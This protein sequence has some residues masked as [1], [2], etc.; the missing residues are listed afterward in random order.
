[1]ILV[2]VYVVYRTKI[3]DQ[4]ISKVLETVPQDGR[5]VRT[6]D[7]N[8]RNKICVSTF[9]ECHDRG[10]PSISSVLPNR[11]PHLYERINKVNGIRSKSRESV[12]DGR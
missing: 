6:N 7:T 10:E 11:S 3:F 8:L 5:N 9:E 2:V 1:M 4:R 12:R